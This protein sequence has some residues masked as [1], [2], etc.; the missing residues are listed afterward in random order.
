M[1][2]VLTRRKPGEGVVSV[3]YTPCA[4]SELQADG[5][6]SDQEQI[7]I[8]EE[9]PREGEEEEDFAGSSS[10]G[11]GSGG[12]GGIFHLPKRSEFTCGRVSEGVGG[13]RGNAEGRTHNNEHYNDIEIDDDERVGVPDGPGRDSLTG[14]LS[15]LKRSQVS[16]QTV[17]AA[18]GPRNSPPGTIFTA[19][20][21]STDRVKLIGER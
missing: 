3:R 4:K 10:S 9:D 6:D 7:A 5:A 12:G 11:G 18:N 2:G 14:T 8:V 16:V 13:S 21:T 17:V 15:Q 1:S 19:Q 20:S